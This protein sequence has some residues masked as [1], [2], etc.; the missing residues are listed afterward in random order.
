MRLFSGEELPDQRAVDLPHSWNDRDT[1][2]KGLDYY[3]GPAVYW[4][5]FKRPGSAD[6]EFP[7]RWRLRTGGFYGSAEVL[8]NRRRV[9][10]FEGE[11]LGFDVDV[12][13]ELRQRGDHQLVLSMTNRRPLHVLP[14]KRLPDFLL[15]GG[16]AGGLSLERVPALRLEEDET[17]IWTEHALTDRA[18]VH[19]DWRLVNETNEPLQASVVWSV[20]NPAGREAAVDRHEA[21]TAHPSTPTTSLRTNLSVTDPQR[22]SPDT[23]TLYTARCE[24]FVD[25]QLIDRFERRF[26][27]RLAEFTPQGFFLNGERVEL[28]GFNRHEAM[29]GLGNALPDWLQREDMRTIRELGG[30]FVRLAHY[31]QQTAVL[32]ACDEEGI[33]VYPEIASWKSVRGG[34]WLRAAERQ[35][36]RMLRRDRHH[37]SIILWGMGNESRHRGAYITL[38]RAVEELAPD[39]PATYAENHLYRARRKRTLGLPGVWGCNYEV[40]VLDDAKQHAQLGAVVMSECCAKQAIRGEREQERAQIESTLAVWDAIE[41][42]PYVAGYALWGLTDYATMHRQRYTRYNGRLDAWRTPKMAAALFAARHGEHPFIRLFGSWSMAAGNAGAPRE[43]DV[44]SNCERVDLKLGDRKIESLSGGL[45]QRVT[46]DF[47]AQ[48]LIAVGHRG[49]QTTQHRLALHGPGTRIA[50]TPETR[51]PLHAL[52][53]EWLAVRIE[54][55]DDSGRLAADWNGDIELTVEGPAISYAYT[56]S[57]RIPITAGQARTMVRGTGSPGTATLRAS[58][59]DLAAMEAEV[60]FVPGPGRSNEI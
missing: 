34:R 3:I 8:L 45:Y 42:L 57:G 24:V 37:P 6:Q 26:G 40:D 18:Q 44:I 13:E 1:F 2:Q 50:L 38:G 30:N 39:R 46:V 16:L 9:G 54:I 22:W 33:L 49:E 52:D 43:I 20:L 14:G 5:E 60:L 48:D 28:R 11:Y 10:V 41:G 32:D 51:G 4:R 19:I 29:P 17:R 35:M 15:H 55:H 53:R 25:D 12:T 7:E 27:I 21:V 59:S 47:E 58:S 36:R 56:H 23:P 31:P